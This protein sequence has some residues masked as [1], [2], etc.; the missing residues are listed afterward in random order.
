MCK[1]LSLFERQFEGM[2][3]MFRWTKFAGGSEYVN[4]RPPGKFGLIRKICWIKYLE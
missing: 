4:F 1:V 2:V 3:E